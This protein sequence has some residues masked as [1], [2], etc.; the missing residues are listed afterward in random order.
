MG[1][2]NISESSSG[3]PSDLL[4]MLRSNQPEIGEFKRNG[5]HL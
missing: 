4:S 2:E 1:T 3:I 5:G